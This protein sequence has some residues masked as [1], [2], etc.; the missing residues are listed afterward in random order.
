M[1]WFPVR[2]VF[3]TAPHETSPLLRSLERGCLESLD[4]VKLVPSQGLNILPPEIMSSP[5]DACHHLHSIRADVL[6]HLAVQLN[7]I[8]FGA[9][10][11]HRLAA[12]RGNSAR[13]SEHF[14]SR[15]CVLTHCVWKQFGFTNQI[16]R[17]QSMPIVPVVS[18]PAD[19]REESS[20]Q[21]DICFQCTSLFHKRD[22]HRCQSTRGY[23]APPTAMKPD[24]GAHIT[25][26]D[27]E[28]GLQFRLR[29]DGSYPSC[30][31]HGLEAEREPWPLWPGPTGWAHRKL[32]FES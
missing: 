12:L 28:G 24:P 13:Q 21:Y 29:C 6:R 9:P 10:V 19:Q 7:T 2:V 25:L 17:C 32:N 20:D 4:V 18:I 31:R 14:P 11:R 22:G 3:V 15:T 1:A 16:R 23:T 30:T 5:F 27:C 8:F 26:L